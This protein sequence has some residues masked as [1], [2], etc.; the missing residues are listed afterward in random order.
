MDPFTLMYLAGHKSLATTMRYIH[1][2]G[3]DAQIK[4]QETRQRMNVSSQVP[5]GHN[6]GHNAESSHSKENLRTASIN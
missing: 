1:L 3:S 5:G 4:L 2:A 6:I